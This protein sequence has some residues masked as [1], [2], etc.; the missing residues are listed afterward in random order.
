MKLL[1]QR[2]AKVRFHDPFNPSVKLDDGKAYR[3]TPLTSANV[4]GADLV[5]ILTDH[6]SYDYAELVKHA[7]VVLDTRNATAQ[8]KRGRS[9][10]HKL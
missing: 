10:I 4:K 7:C 1:E 2:G 6:S 9:K 5:L 3:R 8:V